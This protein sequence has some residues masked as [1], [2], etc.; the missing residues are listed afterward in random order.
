MERFG[1]GIR[2]YDVICHNGVLYLSGVTATEAGDTIAMQA[3]AVLAKIEETLKAHGSSKGSI[4]HADVYLRNAEDVAAFNT[5]WDRWINTE[6]APTR[7]L[8]V[9]RLGREPILVE[10]V[11]TAACDS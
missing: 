1:K 11:I 6:T 8:M 7:A 3:G 10:I 2:Y 4:L 9:T 5:E